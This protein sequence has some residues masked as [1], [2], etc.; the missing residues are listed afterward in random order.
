MNLNI[1]V[2]GKS[3]NLNFVLA[4]NNITGNVSCPQVFGRQTL[5][6]LRELAGTY[7]EFCVADAAEVP[8]SFIHFLFEF[9]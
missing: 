5:D 2:V 8:P 3:K 4:G 7:A 1:L 6:R 9:I